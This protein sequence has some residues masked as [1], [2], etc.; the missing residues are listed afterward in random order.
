AGVERPA[1]PEG[2]DQQAERRHDPGQGQSEYGHL[3]AGARDPGRK[4][5]GPSRPAGLGP[6]RGRGWRGC[7]RDA[8]RLASTALNWR[9]LKINTGT[10]ASSRI[11]ASALALA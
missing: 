4:P 11:T 1:R 8:H 3:Q 10:T 6:D 2:V 9:R 5:L 7:R